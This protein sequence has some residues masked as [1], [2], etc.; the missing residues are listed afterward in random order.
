MRQAAAEYD[1][2]RRLAVVVISGPGGVG[3]TA[4]ATQWLHRGSGRYE[5]GAL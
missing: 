5:G 4:L 1:P 3:K 2:V